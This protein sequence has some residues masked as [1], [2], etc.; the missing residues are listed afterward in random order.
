MQIDWCYQ[1]QNPEI[2][3]KKEYYKKKLEYYRK[4]FFIHLKLK[5]L[6]MNK[7]YI[8]LYSADDITRTPRRMHRYK[9]NT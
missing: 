6:Q 8:S 7:K 4:V 2:T 9:G 5:L 1:S 3:K